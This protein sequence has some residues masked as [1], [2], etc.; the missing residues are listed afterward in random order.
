VQD[1]ASQE[2]D[3]PSRNP[4][5]LI[6]VGDTVWVE[7]SNKGPFKVIARYEHP[8]GA[9]TQVH[10]PHDPPQTY[11]SIRVDEEA[12]V[13]EDT[14]GNR[15]VLPAGTLTHD[16]PGSRLRDMREKLVVAGIWAWEK[17]EF[18]LWG[19]ICGLAA[20]LAFA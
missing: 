15:V 9:P 1:E 5:R 12:W 10:H 17:R 4:L 2:P 16:A 13:C 18:A 20:K 6:E 11:E 19:A 3:P 7:L 8:L 14:K